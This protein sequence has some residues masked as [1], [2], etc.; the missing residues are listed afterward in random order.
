MK[1]RLCSSPALPPTP[2]PDRADR[3]LPGAAVSD[4]LPPRH[5]AGDGGG[6]ARRARRRRARALWRVDG[7]DDRARMPAPG[8]A[9]AC[10]GWRCWAV[11]RGQTRRRSRALRANA[12]AMIDAGRYDEMI[13]MNV[14]LSFHADRLAERE[15]TQAYVD[16]RCAAPER[17][18]LVRQNSPSPRVS[19]AGRCCPRFGPAARGLRRRRRRDALEH[20]ARDR[21]CRARRRAGRGP[22][23]LWAHADDDGAP[24]RGQRGARARWLARIG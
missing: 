9:A 22:R 20:L 3:R 16:M 7:R 5:A 2:R 21:G 24:G 6:A 17:P 15:P 14:L 23:A 19:T 10:A 13:E 18:Q 12:F 4:A 8:A 1:T 11:R